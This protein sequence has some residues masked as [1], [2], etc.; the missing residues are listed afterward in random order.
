LQ[1]TT[2]RKLLA[3]GRRFRILAIFDDCTRESLATVA[4]IS[5][6]GRRVALEL[7]VLIAR[8]GRPRQSS[9]TMGPI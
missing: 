9:A 3:S 6:S 5:L 1:Q 2:A 8:R 4:D 7:D